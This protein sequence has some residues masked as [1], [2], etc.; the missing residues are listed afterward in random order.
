M[1]VL[2]YF[3]TFKSAAQRFPKGIV[4]KRL[5]SGEL[6][7]A[8]LQAMLDNGKP[9]GCLRRGEMFSGMKHAYCIFTHLGGTMGQP[10]TRLAARVST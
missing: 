10:C 8:K 5:P 1:G 6:S 4:Q 9:F 2:N 7:K 3:F